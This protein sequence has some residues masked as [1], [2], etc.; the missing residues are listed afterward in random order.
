MKNLFGGSTTESKTTQQSQSEA[1]S[2][3][4]S[5]DLSAPEL[6][7]LREPFAKALTQL[8]GGNSSDLFGIP[9][10]G[11]EPKSAPITQVEQDMLSALRTE[12]QPRRDLIDKTMAG[13]FLPGQAGANPFLQA[14]IEAAQRPTLRGLEETLTRALPGRFTQG[15]QF[16][17]PKGSSAFDR[18][19]SIMAEAALQTNADIATR[20][21]SENY[22]AERNRQMQAVTFSGDE[23]SRGIEKLQAS[24]LPRLIE[25]LGIS[26]GMDEF[27]TR[28][29]ALTDLLKTLT[30]A[31]GVTRG[32]AAQ[33][34]SSSS[35][36]G[37][38]TS[39]G[40]T[41]GGVIPGIKGTVA[42]PPGSPT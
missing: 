40:D 8:F 1:Q 42:F 7:A 37:T 36:S 25:D 22:D 39:R 38:S 29:A 17:Q 41:Y 6:Q 14:A 34:T 31:T 4:R 11:I 13:N 2:T 23:L 3:A 26:R 33:S 19:A 5:F 21:S 32:D 9:K 20:M 18:A 28:L 12:G 30:A 10:S 27:K 24:A 16:I 35:S 15:G